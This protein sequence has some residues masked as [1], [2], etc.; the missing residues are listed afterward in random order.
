MRGHPVA[1]MG[2]RTLAKASLSQL[3]APT[4]IPRLSRNPVLWLTPE[5]RLPTHLTLLLLAG[6]IRSVGGMAKLSVTSATV[7]PADS[8]RLHCLPSTRAMDGTAN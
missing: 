8:L 5:A 1:G 7:L 2:V 6:M 4:T 3:R